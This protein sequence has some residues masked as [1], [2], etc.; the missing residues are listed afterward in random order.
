MREKENLA[1]TFSGLV[2]RIVLRTN[3][4]LG[5]IFWYPFSILNDL[6]ILSRSRPEAL[7]PFQDFSTKFSVHI[8]SRSPKGAKNSMFFSCRSGCGACRGMKV[9]G[10]I[11]GPK[12]LAA[13]QISSQ[14]DL[15][16]GNYIE[17]TYWSF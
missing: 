16:H 14:L 9:S 8:Q 4:V 2:V 1:P 10:C 11:Q 17:K 6:K 3:L 7:G 13:C 5:A 12:N 15:K